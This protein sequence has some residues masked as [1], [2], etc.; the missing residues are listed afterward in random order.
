[1]QTVERY[2]RF[3]GGVK[4]RRTLKQAESGSNQLLQ[5]TGHANTALRA[6][7]SSPRQPAAERWR[8]M[9]KAE[10]MRRRTCWIAGIVT[11]LLAVVSFCA[12]LSLPDPAAPGVT[13]ANVERI[14]VGMTQREVEEVVGR[15]PQTC[16]PDPMPITDNSSAAY[17][18]VLLW[19]D[20]ECDILVYLDRD[21]V[22][23]DREGVASV[24]SRRPT[25]FDRLRKRV[26]L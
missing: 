18:T 9:K 25:W 8:S 12:C 24:G 21:G 10:A 22:V 2:G 26:G 3:S 16:I 1:M 15:P 17:H 6:T 23:I 20:M 14:V 19:S 4:V 7:T 11:S 13:W 5:Q